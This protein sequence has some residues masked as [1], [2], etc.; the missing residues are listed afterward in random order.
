MKTLHLSLLV[1]GALCVNASEALAFRQPGWISAIAFS[2]DG[3][4]L[5]NGCSDKGAQPA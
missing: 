1:G 4:L 5:A 2:P 3:K